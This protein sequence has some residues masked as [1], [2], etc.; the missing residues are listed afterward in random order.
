MKSDSPDGGD[1]QDGRPTKTNAADDLLNSD[2]EEAAMALEEL[3]VDKRLLRR[4]L[5][6][7]SNQPESSTTIFSPNSQ[8]MPLSP[9]ESRDTSRS[10]GQSTSAPADAPNTWK[11]CVAVS[12]AP[13]A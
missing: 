3:S 9:E 12:P 13:A 5:R 10:H 11:P 8:G 1:T 4:S 6:E 2:T 7:P